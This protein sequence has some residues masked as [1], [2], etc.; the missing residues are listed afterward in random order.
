MY[1]IQRLYHIL[2]IGHPKSN[3]HNT[4]S[5][6]FFSK[7]VANIHKFSRKLKKK[8]PQLHFYAKIH[9]LCKKYTTELK[10][11]QQDKLQ[12]LWWSDNKESV[13]DLLDR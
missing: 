10:N 11:F 1:Y 7:S 13:P 8:R 6:T 5:N 4:K 12:F 2:F 9:L 3:W